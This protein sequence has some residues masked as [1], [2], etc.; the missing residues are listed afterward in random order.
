MKVK[1]I[2]TV[3]TILLFGVTSLLFSESSDTTAIP[4]ENRV[5]VEKSTMNT[6]NRSATEDEIMKALGGITTIQVMKSA[7]P[8][9]VSQSEPMVL[10][11]DR[12]KVIK[13]PKV[14]R[15]TKRKV[16]TYRRAKP[17]ATSTAME[18]LP[19]AKSYPMSYDVSKITE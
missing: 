19:M 5:A 9:I 2:G 1:K 16:R 10:K 7:A 17:V 14:K 18:D 13:K 11:A 8:Q 15:K 6:S 12:P 3:A 4:V